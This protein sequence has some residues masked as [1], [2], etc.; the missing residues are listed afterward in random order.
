MKNRKYLELLLL[1]SIVAV[2]AMG[3]ASAATGDKYINNTGLDT[4]DGNSWDTPYLTIQQGLDNVANAGTVNI[5]SG[6]YT[7]TGNT[8]LDVKTSDVT[9]KGSDEDPTTIDGQGTNTALTVNSGEKVTIKNL[10]IQNTPGAI[11]NNGGDL[12]VIGSNLKSNTAPGFG[13]AIAVNSGTLTVT[14]S[15]FT[16]NHADYSGAIGIQSASGTV[17]GSTFTGNTAGHNGGAIANDGI[18]SV[19]DSTFTGNSAGNFG[20][21]IASDGT[22][23]ITGSN[24]ESNTAINVGG[25]IANI[26][27][28]TLT[29]NFNRFFGNTAPSGSAI[30]SNSGTVDATNN[31]WGSNRRSQ[32]QCSW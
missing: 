22:L 27:P 31:W 1:V 15:T 13:G 7:G 12:T 9:I 8:N 6:T 26:Y 19:T 17:S 25:A 16:N 20:G 32:Q 18:L 21:A 30:N 2:M 14:G 3:T 4:N 10:T 24:F 29:A 11:T 28:G 5:A 23:T